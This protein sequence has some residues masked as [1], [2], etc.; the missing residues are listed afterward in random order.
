MGYPQQTRNV[1]L[2]N[3]SHCAE[4]QGLT[5]NQ[6]LFR[7]NGSGNTRAFTD[8][9]LSIFPAGFLVG[10]AL[11]DLETSLLGFLPGKA[12]L[13]TDFKIKAFPSSGTANIYSGRITYKKTLLWLIPI[14]RTFTN[15]SFNSPS[16]VLF[17]DNFPGGV[18]PFYE[19]LESS[20]NVE[21]NF[22]ARYNYNLDVVENV[23]FIPAVSALDVG[24]GATTLNTSDYTRTYTVNNRPSGSRAIPFDSF[25]TSFNTNATNEIHL[26]F[27]SRNGDWLAD[28]LNSASTSF[29]CGFICSPPSISGSNSI[30]TTGNYSVSVPGGSSVTWSVS[31][32]NAGTVTQNGSST[33]FT[34]YSSF[35]GNFSIRATLSG[36]ASDC[37]STTVTKSVTAQGGISFTTQGPD[38]YGYL[39]VNV[40]GGSAPYVYRNYSGTLLTSNSS[41]VNLYWGCNPDR[42]FVDAQTQCGTATAFRLIYSGCG[43]FGASAVAV[44]PNPTSNEIFLAKV[45]DQTE[46]SASLSGIAETTLSSLGNSQNQ[47]T[48]D[49][50]TL[51]LYDY[52]GTMIKSKSYKKGMQELKLGLSDLKKG[53]YILRIIGKEVDET[54]QIVKE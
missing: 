24:S 34:K 2:S 13:D 10:V 52:T 37:G 9:V 40:T 26:S 27:N 30:C 31:P 44:Y 45:Q 7:L 42:L 43:G 50:V 8:I 18:G 23:N 53:I 25:T 41:S 19:L 38:Q 36:G 12:T 46:V 39:Y 54:H 21:S 1:A 5:S 14:T 15:K 29:D 33:V 6:Q 47:R 17:Q 11:G 16:N 3:A 28:E 32:S 4:P 51:Q 22:F 35:F 48:F 20:S 49:D